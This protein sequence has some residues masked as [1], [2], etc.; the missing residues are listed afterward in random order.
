MCTAMCLVDC[1]VLW[2]HPYTSIEA[3]RNVGVMYRPPS[4]IPSLTA[5]GAHS[6]FKLSGLRPRGGHMS[7]STTATPALPEW[8]NR[9]LTDT[10]HV[11]GFDLAAAVCNELL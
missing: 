11:G 10:Y 2:R 5:N 4:T 8:F 7:S 9:D 3:F 6:V 1:E